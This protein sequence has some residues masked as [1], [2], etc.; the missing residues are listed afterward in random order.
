MVDWL[1]AVQAQDYAMAKWAVGI[2]LPGAT[3]QELEDSIN[4][5][6][7]VRTHVMRPTWHFVTAANVRW[8]LELTAPHIK[9]GIKTYQT[10][11]GLDEKLF[12]RTNAIIET[13]L[14]DKN[15]MT[16]SEIVDEFKKKKI[17]ANNL[18][19]TH[20]MFDAE[21]NGIVCNGPMRGK[22]FTY[23]LIDELIPPTKALSREEAL[24]KLAL[25][26]FT[27]HGP[28][29]VQDFAWWS[30]L[31]AVDARKGLEL[32][33]KLL[34]N[35]I[36]DDKTYWFRETGLNSNPVEQRSVQFLPAYDEFMIGYT[37]RG[38]SLEPKYSKLTLVGNGIFRPVIV[39]DGKIVGIWLRTIK[40]DHAAVSTKFFQAKE[41]LGK[42]EVESLLEP[43]GRFVNLRI[44]V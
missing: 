11:L 10:K 22:Q 1:G 37:D 4:R 33:K 39:R 28:A 32:T 21:L 2:R 38:A 30:G 31:P 40:K 16:R 24:A 20:I 36:V 29:T 6:E 18:Q 42:K 7:I 13:L 19:A 5:V 25:K 34:T 14:R 8:M 27:S 17:K 15:Y 23:A 44:K 43:Y 3:D 26:Y 12:K 41:K 35:V 9:W